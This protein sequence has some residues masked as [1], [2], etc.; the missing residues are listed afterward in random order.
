MCDRLD[1]L[2]GIVFGIEQERRLGAVVE[3]IWF[4]F[5]I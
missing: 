3:K 4:D 5:H 2:G 1:L